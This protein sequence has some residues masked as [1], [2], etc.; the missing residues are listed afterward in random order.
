M[1]T[2]KII[3]ILCSLPIVLIT[4]YFV[5]FLGICLLILRYFVY[6]NNKRYSVSIYL[7]VVGIFILIPKLIYEILK[8][9]NNKI[10]YLNEIVNSNTYIKLIDY[11]KFLFILAVILLIISFVLKKAIDKLR[12][13]I[14]SY[15]YKHEKIL[16]EVS[17]ENDMK[18][19]LKQE[20][21]KNT[22][23][24]FCPHCGADNILTENVGNC[25]Y[26]RRKIQAKS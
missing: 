4:M 1:N 12:N 9:F 19:K 8:L 22:Q 17:K 25:K 15:I 6:G 20:K 10:P 3:K 7:I 11:C 14:S 16:T 13:F 18:I 26:C 24:V 2:D 5:P 21:A 23:V